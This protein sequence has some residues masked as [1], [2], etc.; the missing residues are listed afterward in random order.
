MGG[1][2]R[3]ARRVDSETYLRREHLGLGNGVR[4]MKV[5]MY[6]T[7]SGTNDYSVE[8]VRALGR[9]GPL[10]VLTVADTRLQPGDCA[11]LLPFIPPF[12][13]AQPRWWKALRMAFAYLVLIG[14]CL[15]APRQTVLHIQFLRFERLEAWLFGALQRLGV[16]LVFSA[17]N[18]LP[19]DEAQWHAGFYRNWY[20]GVDALHILSQQVLKDIEQ[21]VNATPRRTALIAHGPYQRM[22]DR[23]GKID[24]VVRRQALGISADRFVVLQ[25]GL[26]KEYKGVDRLVDAVCGLP[27]VIRPLLVLA[28]AGPVDYLDR[29][30][31]RMDSAG[32]SDCLLWLRRYVDDDDLC[33]LIR[34][35]DLVVFPYTKVSQS[36]ALYLSLTFGSACLCNDLP[37]FREMLPD[38]DIFFVNSADTVQFSQRLMALIQTPSELSR[39]RNLG[40]SLADAK[41]NWSLI[42]KSTWDLYHDVFQS[43]RR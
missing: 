32:R 19:H 38:D 42:A 17:H 10:T 18:A 39:L 5:V 27:E 23:F 1:C 8:L 34:I 40:A 21:R 28:G 3:V 22:L 4:A 15:R 37:G 25:Y 29:V 24:V 20:S 9:L 11:L 33:G 7:L 6:D 16:R 26:F 41:F 13:A 30:Q 35:A 36:G 12:A 2:L 43:T 14:C 31:K